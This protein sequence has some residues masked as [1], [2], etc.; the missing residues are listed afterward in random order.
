M[1]VNEKKCTG[2]NQIKLIEDFG[3]NYDKRSGKSYRR[4]HCK[5]CRNRTKQLR[6]YNIKIGDYK[7][8]YNKQG[9]KCY[10]CNVYHIKLVIDHNHT[11]NRIRALLCDSC[12]KGLGFFKD[13]S[14]TLLA[15]SEYL[16]FYNLYK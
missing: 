7:E 8:M 4:S 5:T 16:Q 14:S 9:G 13:N 1:E 2:C 10:I 15:A 12:N 3:W 11:T 6:K